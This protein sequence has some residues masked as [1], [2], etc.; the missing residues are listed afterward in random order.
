MQGGY[1]SMGPIKILLVED[2]YIDQ[3]VFKRLVESEKLNY[4]YMI[5]DSVQDSREILQK[6]TFDVVV[7]D[8][9]L[10]DGT[11]FDLITLVYDAPIIFTTGAGDEE[12]AVKAM[13]CGVFDYLIKD[14]D[15]NYIKLLPAV[16]EKSI[17]SKK[18][19]EQLYMLSKA[20]MTVKDSIYIADMNYKIKFV[21]TAFCK[22]YGYEESELI[23][24]ESAIL[25]SNPRDF[26]EAKNYFLKKSTGEFNHVRKNGSVFPV[27]LSRSIV[28]DDYG[29]DGA[30]ISI[31]RDITE[32]KEIDRMKSEFVNTVSHEIR[33]PLTVMLSL[34]QLLISNRNMEEGKLTRYYQTMYRESKRLSDLV[35]DF[36]DIQRMESGKQVF[37]KEKICIV[38]VIDEV[39]SLY[40]M[41]EAYNIT[42]DMDKVDY[43]PIFADMP[44]MVQLLTNLVSN[45]IKYSPES[46]EVKIRVRETDY[47]IVVS[48]IDKG[49]GI[50][51]ESLSML[52]TKFYRVDNTDHRK[53]GGTGLGLVICKE[54]VDAHEGTIGV[55][56]KFNEGSEFYFTI[57][58][59]TEDGEY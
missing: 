19:R 2:D 22:T 10:G 6:N 25:W 33:T 38:D 35:N 49:L 39:I 34:S 29:D 56:S 9:D 43:D 14:M 16:I 46:S 58:K 54:I 31:V 55:K 53:V 37:S 45:A 7:V 21:N 50:P 44:K 36:L 18:D 51:E 48:V 1:M 24:R 5:S 26:Q 3:M 42:V 52:F 8:Y 15:K 57:P 23:G 32:S 4:E 27:S 40:E 20:V 28:K 12:T 59:F 11:A 41:S 47:D 30:V 13:R 17:K